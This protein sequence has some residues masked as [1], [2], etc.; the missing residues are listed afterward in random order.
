MGASHSSHS[1][2]LLLGQKY[3]HSWM[4]F[5]FGSCAQENEKFKYILIL[6]STTKQNKCTMQFIMYSIALN[7]FLTKVKL[8]KL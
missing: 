6:Q 8:N 1:L 4:N 7:A 2:H 5:V 3:F